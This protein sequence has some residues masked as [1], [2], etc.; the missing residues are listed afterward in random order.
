M[1]QD[2]EAASQ[3]PGEL[4]FFERGNEVGQGAVVDPAPALSRGNGEADGQVSLPNAGRPEEHH[5]LL[6]L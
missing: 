4:G 3:L 1:S 2:L 5:V 6:S